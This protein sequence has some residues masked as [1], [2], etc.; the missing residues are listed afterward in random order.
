MTGR[1]VLWPTWNQVQDALLD[2]GGNREVLAMEH[3]LR[4]ASKASTRAEAAKEEQRQRQVPMQR[5]P[6]SASHFF[7]P[8]E[9]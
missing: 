1:P 9:S 2:A 3:M 4:H 7:D 8:W 6:K 5:V